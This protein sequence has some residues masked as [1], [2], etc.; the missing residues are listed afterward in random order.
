MKKTINVL[1]LAGLAVTLVSCNKAGGSF[2]FED[3]VNLLKTNNGTVTMEAKI[4]Y[5]DGTE[6]TAYVN[7]LFTK[8]ATLV[9]YDS[10]IE[11]L[12]EDYVDYGFVNVDGG[13]ARYSV[14]SSGQLSFGG[15]VLAGEGAVV[16]DYVSS[17]S[18]LGNATWEALD[19]ATAS[20][21]EFTHS[22]I[23]V[24]PVKLISS[25]IGVPWIG[26]YCNSALTYAR[27][28]K[29]NGVVSMDVHSTFNYTNPLDGKNYDSDF[30]FTVTNIGTTTNSAVDT[31]LATN[32]TFTALSD[33]PDELKAAM[34]AVS[35][36]VLPFVPLTKYVNIEIGKTALG[37]YT[38][39]SVEDYGTGDQETTAF[40]GIESLGFER[41]FDRGG[42]VGSGNRTYTVKV[43]EKLLED[44]TPKTPKKVRMIQC[45]FVNPDYLGYDHGSGIMQ[46][47]GSIYTYPF[48]GDT[49]I[50]KSSQ[51]AVNS[52]L[53]ALKDLDN[54]TVFPTLDF[55]EWGDVIYMEDYTAKNPASC[56]ALKLYIPVETDEQM[57]EIRKLIF[58]QLVGYKTWVVEEDYQLYWGNGDLYY[59][60]SYITIESDTV[61]VD[62]DETADKVCVIDIWFG[63]NS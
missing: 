32:P 43:F 7:N 31:Y 54:E 39:W 12:G 59:D 61:D 41:N 3:A 6:E 57:L 33:W 53:S 20:A 29:T 11:S 51:G 58:D 60:D 15:W 63:L 8:D 25:L 42:T 46:I 9:D 45:N 21:T 19:E 56:F 48:D 16:T 23:H 30:A 17:V 26:Y 52:Y 13:V 40:A 44:A 1:V 18:L 36:G 49:E 28:S 2:R 5:T 14:P 50:I 55:G 37:E 34:T 35:G 62:G 47:I 27:A 24:G 4:Q 38:D 10:K 22:T